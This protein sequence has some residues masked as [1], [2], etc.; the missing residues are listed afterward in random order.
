MLGASDALFY[1][2][3]QSVKKTIDMRKQQNYVIQ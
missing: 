2:F 3:K 1:K